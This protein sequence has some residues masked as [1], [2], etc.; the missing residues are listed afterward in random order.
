MTGGRVEWQT[1]QIRNGLS[2]VQLSIVDITNTTLT[3]HNWGKCMFRM[4]NKT[5]RVSQFID[6]RHYSRLIDMD[7][8]MYSS[9]A[10]FGCNGFTNATYVEVTAHRSDGNLVETQ[11]YLSKNNSFDLSLANSEIISGPTENEENGDVLMH[12]YGIKGHRLPKHTLKVRISFG[13]KSTLDA[14]IWC[15]FDNITFIIQEYQN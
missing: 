5:A 15:Y 9:S 3:N 6:L 11:V 4:M 10:F 14:D 1:I 12:P 13:V 2:V 8:A 7:K